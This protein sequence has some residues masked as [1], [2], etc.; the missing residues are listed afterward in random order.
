MTRLSSM[1][2]DIVGRVASSKCSS[3]TWRCSSPRISPARRALLETPPVGRIDMRPWSGPWTAGLRGVSCAFEDGLVALAIGTS[4]LGKS[5]ISVK[6]DL[7]W[8]YVITSM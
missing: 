8:L 3:R 6:E 5:D 2:R 7:L 1:A 4:T